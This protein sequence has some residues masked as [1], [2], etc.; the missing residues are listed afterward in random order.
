MLSIRHMRYVVTR[1]KQA[2]DLRVR[3]CWRMVDEEMDMVFV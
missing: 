1:F 2:Y 3:F